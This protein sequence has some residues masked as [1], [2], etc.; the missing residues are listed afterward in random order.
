MRKLSITLSFSILFSI[1]AGC[2]ST[3]AEDRQQSQFENLL[4]QTYAADQPGAVVVISRDNQV[5][6]SAARG[7]ADIELDVPL[8]KEHILLL[9]SLTKQ[10]TAAAILQ[11]AQQGHLTLDDTVAELL[12]DIE[13]PD[14]TVHQLL[15]HTSGIKSYTNIPGYWTDERMRRDLTTEQLIE[16]IMAEEADFAPGEDMRYNNSGYVLLGAIIEQLSDKPWYEY[17]AEDLLQPAGIEHTRF[18]PAADIVPGRVSGYDYQEGPVNTPWISMTQP[19]AAGALSATALDVDR[20]QRALHQGHIIDSEWLQ[21]MTREDDISGSYGYGLVTGSLRGQP[22]VLHSGGVNGFSSFAL[23]LPEQQ[24]SVVVLSNYFLYQPDTQKTAFRLAAIALDQPFPIEKEVV[25]LSAEQLNKVT[26]TYEIESGTKRTLHLQDGQL[27]SHR[28]GGRSV[29]VE[30]VDENQFVLQNSLVYFETLSNQEGKVTGVNFYQLGEA[31]P[32][33]AEK[34]SDSVETRLRIELDPEQMERL[35]GDYEIQPGFIISIATSNGQITGQA[36][37]QPA[38]P[39]YAEAEDVLYNDEHG[40]ELRF[41]LEADQP[42]SGLVLHQAGQR[43]PASR[44]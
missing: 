20:W 22:A 26:G 15:N 39:L 5:V 37:G 17:I 12:P 38:F 44:L 13:L 32:E 31:E 18:Y 28:E 8:T 3:P 42:A 30:A 27:I 14:I 33:Y 2:A 43:I 19:H 11:L 25:Q 16:V 6:Y 29:P 40:I 10:Y 9:A 1:T 36:T 24:L 7:M 35:M 23:W 4:Q 41:E 21:L 34:V